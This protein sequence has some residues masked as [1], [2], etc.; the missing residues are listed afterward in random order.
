M[1]EIE[2][3]KPYPVEKIVEKYIKVPTPYPVKVAVPVEKIKEIKV[4][5]FIP[6]PPLKT[7]HHHNQQN[8]IGDPFSGFPGNFNL[9]DSFFAGTKN[10]ENLKKKHRYNPDNNNPQDDEPY[11][12]NINLKGNRQHQQQQFLQQQQ[13]NQHDQRQQNQHEQQQRQQNH[14]HQLQQ[15]HQNQQ[16]QFNHNHQQQ[17]NPAHNNNV[18]PHHVNNHQNHKTHQQQQNQQQQSH[19]PQFAVVSIPKNLHKIPFDTPQ[20]PSG[21]TLNTNFNNNN[22]ANSN[23]QKQKAQNH[24]HH[25]PHAQN[26]NGPGSYVIQHNYPSQTLK[27]VD[28][29][30][31]EASTQYETYSAVPNA[32]YVQQVVTPQNYYQAQLPQQEILPIP[33]QQILYP[34]Q[35]YPQQQ[36]F[37]QAS[38]PQYQIQ[39]PNQ[40][41]IPQQFQ[42]PQAIVNPEVFQPSFGIPQQQ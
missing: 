1:K 27:P 34:P 31:T 12:R 41:Q 32:Q 2:V 9:D 25:L 26:Q 15:N 17:R 18:I 10:H 7:A 23:N 24:P 4:P 33:Q 6:A 40:Q 8:S 21:F 35:A 37:A 29:H 20:P 36:Q 28:D 39:Y 3:P 5:V 19:N 11:R 22:N 13:Q 14:N 16:Q 42:Q 30:V 38:E